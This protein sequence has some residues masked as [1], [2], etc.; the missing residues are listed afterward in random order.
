[1]DEAD[2]NARTKTQMTGIVTDIGKIDV[3]SSYRDLDPE[4]I[5]KVSYCQQKGELF[6]LSCEDSVVLIAA[7]L[8]TALWYGNDLTL[9]TKEFKN[10]GELALFVSTLL[11]THQQFMGPKTAELFFTRAKHYTD[12]RNKSKPLLSDPALPES[13]EPAGPLETGE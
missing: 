9:T 12:E 7:P 5:R 3:K 4:V 8:N 6:G 11:Y 10:G 13:T 1:M 2:K